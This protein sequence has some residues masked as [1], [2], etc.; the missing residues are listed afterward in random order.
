MKRT[1]L[2]WFIEYRTRRG[3][4]WLNSISGA[5]TKRGC[6]QEE[7]DRTLAP[8]TKNSAEWLNAYDRFQRRKFNGEIRA[9]RVE[10]TWETDR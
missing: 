2:Q 4:P 7:L 3:H 6:L 8:W 9:V 10:M 5:Q 1:Q